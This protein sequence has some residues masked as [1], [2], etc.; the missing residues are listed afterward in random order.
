MAA[1]TFF[2]LPTALWISRRRS[3]TKNVNWRVFGLLLIG[4]TLLLR[5]MYLGNIELLKEEAYY[6]NYAQHLAPGYLDHPP[7]VAL[8]ISFGTL[9]FGNN[10]LGVRF[11]AFIC[12]FIT[13]L[14]V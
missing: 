14:Y 3:P 12:W 8:L 9:V 2:S 10:E 13:A 1:T 6:W 7:M 4:Y 5:L 11:G